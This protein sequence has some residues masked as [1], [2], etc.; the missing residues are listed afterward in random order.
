MSTTYLAE[1]NFL[2]PNATFIAEL[3]AFVLILLVLGKWVVP[4]INK[5]L[6]DRQASIR[7]QFDELE[8]AK[9]DANAAEQ[10]YRSQLAEARHEAARIRED[11]R[12]QGAAIVAEMREQAQTESD[13]ILT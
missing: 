9:A 10:E 5:A 7:N 13:R 1:S 11:A 4:P 3:I 8:R 2:V 12:E 6:S